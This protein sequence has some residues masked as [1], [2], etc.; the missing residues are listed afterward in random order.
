M[1]EWKEINLNEIPNDREFLV[2]DGKNCWV[3]QILKFGNKT[4]KIN[5]VTNIGSYNLDY[6]S[7]GL[8]HW[9]ELPELPGVKKNKI[10]CSDLTIMVD[11]S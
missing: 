11:Y 2:T 1:T 10:E 7:N 4:S 3:A 8:T 5:I 9:S 6:Y